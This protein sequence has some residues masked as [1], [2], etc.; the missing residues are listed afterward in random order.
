MKNFKTAFLIAVLAFLVFPAAAQALDFS[1][2]FNSGINAFWWD[3]ETPGDTTVVAA[4]QQIEMTQGASAASGSLRFKYSIT[5][6]FIASVDYKL[7]NWPYNTTERLG[8][9][10]ELGAVERIGEGANYGAYV[11]HPAGSYYYYGMATSATE[12]RLEY[13]RVANVFTG[14]FYDAVYPSGMEIWSVAGSTAD[15]DNLRLSIWPNGANEGVRVAFDNFRL[16]APNTVVTPE[17]V[18]ALLFL[19]GGGFM[20]FKNHRRKKS[21]PKTI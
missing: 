18:S 17:P 2:D 21:L 14:T 7:L 13:K 8:I 15:I 6:D 11:V 19:L 3:K 10:G 20:V 16:I 9:T 1:D 12:G 5:G 4:N